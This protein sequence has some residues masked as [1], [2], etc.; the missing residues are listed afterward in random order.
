V[1]ARPTDWSAIGE[2]GDPVGGDAYQVAD[3]QRY[4]RDMAQ[5]IRDQ[6]AKLRRIGADGALTGRSMDELR[7][8]ANQM[9]GRL[10]RLDV[11]YT[12]VAGQLGVWQPALETAQDGS[13]VALRRA[14]AAQRQLAA[15]D[16]RPPQ[17]RS[18]EPPTP[19]QLESRLAEERRHEAAVDSAQDELRAARRQLDA[20]L[21]ARDRTAAQVA[22]AIMVSLDAND[23]S[24]SWWDGVKETIHDHADLIKKLSDVC[25]T[26]ATIAGVLALF[27]P[28]LGVVVLV[29]TLLAAAGHLALASAGK[30][31]WT[32][33]AL[34]LV[35]I[36]AL[37]VGARLAKA[38]HAS[39]SVA[40]GTAISVTTQAARGRWASAGPKIA[41]LRA[42][43][44][45]T[46]SSTAARRAAGRQADR[47]KAWAGPKP[48][49]VERSVRAVLDAPRNVS[50]GQVILAGGDRRAARSILV[51]SAAVG[52]VKHPLVVSAADEVFRARLPLQLSYL[53]STALDLGDKAVGGSAAFPDKVRSDW[54][55]QKKDAWT[56]EL[57]S[58]WGS[59]EET[60]AVQGGQLRPSPA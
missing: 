36:G 46:R 17:A 22:D 42:V 25:S 44:G 23:I 60:P 37:G 33:F 15:L 18:A 24:D 51:A 57:G 10:E 16:H 21:E 28:G 49:K 29:A 19:A 32:D 9:A 38:M 39:A 43:Q 59:P 26:I 58:T 3:E 31:S 54:Y 35:A 1:S 45:S 55:D 27:I 4:Y 20:V 6:A 34:D 40:K 52:R 50:V 2:S 56:K 53:F 5:D 47:L 11:R 48:Q 13:L 12:T 41:Q 30:G 7:E 8:T 14:E